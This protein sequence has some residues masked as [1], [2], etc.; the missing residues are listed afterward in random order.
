MKQKSGLTVLLA[1]GLMTLALMAG[2]FPQVPAG[3]PAAD[4]IQKVENGLRKDI[5]IGNPSPLNL[6]ERMKEQGVPGVSIAVIQDFQV[7]WAKGYGVRDIRSGEPVTADTLFQ[8][9]SI[10]K[11]ITAVVTL[12]L[13]Q[14][15][16][17]EP[18]RDVNLY[19][20]R[21]K[22]PENEFTRTE[23]VTIRRILNHTA[24]LTV[25]GFRGYAEGEPVPTILQVLDGLP[26]ANSAPVRVDQ[27]PGSGY[28]YSGGGFTLLQCLVEDVTGRPLSELAAELVFRPAS[29]T[30][31]TLCFCQPSA[32]P[33]AAQASMGH[34]LDPSRKLTAIKGYTF[35]QGGSGCCELWT[36]PTDLCRFVIAIQ[37]ALRG[38]TG[39]I[40]SRET[41]RTMLTALNDSPVG[42]GCFLYR[43]NGADRFGH[44]GGNV[45]FVSRFQGDREGGTGFAVMVNSDTA[46]D[47]PFELTCAIQ[48]AYGWKG[49]RPRTYPDAAAVA[50]EA[51][52]AR[53]QNPADPGLSESG[54]NNRGYRLL[55]AGYP[56]A[57]VGLFQLNCELHPQSANAAD[58]LA[59]AL[60]RT[61]NRDKALAGYRQALRLLD[62]FPEVNK[63]YARNRPATE[64]KIRS[65]EAAPNRPPG[66]GRP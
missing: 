41:A 8:A 9:A 46:R 56:E 42:L 45:G 55:N 3:D 60:E 26:P 22:L 5:E 2:T 37:K 62:Q 28:R 14:D 18:D 31:S 51:R 25:R 36:T 16:V 61:G 34:I 27:V 59:E 21:W 39:A 65:L 66:A 10:T 35:F 11:S 64:E 15:G 24:G 17:L 63:G 48:D 30:R 53:E 58:S 7:Q 4:P 40:L 23:K 44:D 50:A 20:K 12:R 38:D 19:L 33:L 1:A 49:A 47:L 43:D 57:A 32:A 6:M 29:M 52:Q 54:I 13:A